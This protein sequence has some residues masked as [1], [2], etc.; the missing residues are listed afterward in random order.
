METRKIAF[1]PGCS[2]ESSATGFTV[3]LQEVLTRLQMAAPE[4]PDWSCCGATAAHA[5]DHELFLELNL[6]NLALAEEKGFEEIECNIVHSSSF[7]GFV[8]DGR[9]LR[10][11]DRALTCSRPMIGD[12]TREPNA[13]FRVAQTLSRALSCT[14]HRVGWPGLD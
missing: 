8:T 1:Y 13:R 7:P 4:L 12:G 11:P 5:L 14:E 2:L 9:E 10:R 3:S 6:R